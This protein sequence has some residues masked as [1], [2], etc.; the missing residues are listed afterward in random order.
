MSILHLRQGGSN[1]LT[2]DKSYPE[3][4]M[5]GTLRGFWL[6]E[7]ALLVLLNQK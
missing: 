6:Q 7:A 5:K 4:K 2:S 3:V 1:R